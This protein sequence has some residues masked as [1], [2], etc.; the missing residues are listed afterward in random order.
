MVLA[1]RFIWKPNK[2]NREILA[3]PERKGRKGRKACKAYPALRLR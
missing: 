1:L 3:H 2:A